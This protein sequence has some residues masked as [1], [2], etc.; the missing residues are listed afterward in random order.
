MIGFDAAEHHRVGGSGTYDC[1]TTCG[2]C[3]GKGRTAKQGRS[4]RACR[5]TG[6]LMYDVQYPLR[7]WGWDRS[8]CERE[9]HAAGLPVP[10]KSACFFCPAS[11]KP[12]ILGLPSDL[13][14]LS[15][16]MEATYRRGKHWR[17]QQAT[18]VGLGQ[19]YT[20]SSLRQRHPDQ[21]QLWNDVA[22]CEQALWAQEGPRQP[23]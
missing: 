1:R 22:A 8:R 6:Q 15:V 10:V 2:S 14:Q 9:I 7:E 5:G 16:E 21:L 23:V 19:R 4:C 17:D 3:A 12:E 20:W 11:K 18:T 13:Y